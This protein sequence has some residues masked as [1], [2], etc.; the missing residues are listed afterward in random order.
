VP[1]YLPGKFNIVIVEVVAGDAVCI[2]GRK[3]RFRKC[4]IKVSLYIE[5]HK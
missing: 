5:L 4:K 1:T 2:E 3:T